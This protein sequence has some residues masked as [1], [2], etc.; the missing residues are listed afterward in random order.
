MRAV[1]AHAAGDGDIV[2][3]DAVIRQPVDRLRRQLDELAQQ[4]RVVFMLAALQRLLIE[5]LFAVFDALH[6]LEARFR[7]VHAHRGFDGVAADSRHL[8]NDHHARA[9]V[10]RL[11]RR[12]QAR[13]AAADHDHVVVLR[14]SGVAALFNHILFAGGGERA[15]YRFFQRLALG[16]GASDGVDVRAVSHQNAVTQAFKGLGEIDV[17]RIVRHH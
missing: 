13:A 10:V 8:L 15:R 6:R 5:K 9:F 14:R 7:R 4:H 12:R 17:Q 11:N 3:L 16:G 2:Q 1:D